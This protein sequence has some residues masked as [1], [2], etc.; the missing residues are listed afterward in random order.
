MLQV[1]IPKAEYFDESTQTFIE[2]KEQT[3]Q[4]EHSL[5]SLSKWESKWNKPFLTSND[6]STEETLDYIRCMTIT[7][8]VNPAV[9]L[10][11]NDII[12]KQVTDYINASMTATTFNDENNKVGRREVITSEVIYYWMIALNI[13]FECQRWHLNRL[14]TL[15]RVCNIK[16]SPPKKMSQKELISRNRALNEARRKSLQTK[17]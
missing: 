2:I 7:Q 1:T 14:L 11:I 5:V 12:I 3:L 13:P 10:G 15:I 16:N 6:K 8:N 9:Y 4:L 17:G